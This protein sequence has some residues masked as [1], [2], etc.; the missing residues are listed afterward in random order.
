MAAGGPPTGT[1]TFLFTDVEGSTRRWQDDAQGMASRLAQ[2]DRD[3]RAVLE[4]AG[5]HVFSTM[6]DGF[7]AA[8]SS[9]SDAVS[10]ASGV[11][12]AARDLLPVR[13][14]LHTGVAE[15]R[16]GNYFGLAVNRCARLMG[17]AR[18]GQVLL[19]DTTAAFVDPS[20][21]TDLGFHQLKDIDAPER[22]WQ[23]G[24]GGYGPLRSV[25]L[26]GSS[27]L[28]AELSS[29]VGRGAD[30]ARVAAAF[31]DHRLV[32]IVGVGGVGKTRLALRVGA[33]LS[34]RFEHGVQLVELAGVS[35]PESL[36]GAVSAALRLSPSGGSDPR[37]SLLDALQRRQLLLILDNCEH[38]LTSVSRLATDV[39]RHCPRV[40][41]LAT[42]REGLGVAGEQLVPLASL[43]LPTDKGHEMESDS[44]RLFVER[45]REARPD[46]E[47]GGDV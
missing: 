22:V 13:V 27:N 8:F 16:D 21:L 15:E 42:S 3:V 11:V 19:S 9:A 6:G 18:G 28:P 38:L 44:V 1:V 32:T 23:L 31:N 43:G 20:T 29:L 33:D 14:G 17:V 7:A 35:E 36:V 45:A 12:D 4:S 46:F 24:A 34:A 30:V 25:E 39:L 41:V 5:G 47:V 26:F 37:E 10:A 40:V 2:H